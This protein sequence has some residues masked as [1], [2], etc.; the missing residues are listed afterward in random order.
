[1]ETL[2]EIRSTEIS[3][4]I[5]I[6]FKCL[7]PRAKHT[8]ILALSFQ[9]RSVIFDHMSLVDSAQHVLAAHRTLDPVLAVL[10]LGTHVQPQPGDK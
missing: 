4:I 7:E 5:W 2:D 9:Q 10:V 6:P 3:E 8:V 1:M